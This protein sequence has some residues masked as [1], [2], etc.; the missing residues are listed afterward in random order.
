ML[1]IGDKEAFELE[2]VGEVRRGTGLF[3]R[4]KH[5][6]EPYGTGNYIEVYE[7]FLPKEEDHV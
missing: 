4:F 1:E 6:A 3:Y 2:C 7:N 5:A